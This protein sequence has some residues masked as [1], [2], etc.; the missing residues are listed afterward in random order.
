MWKHHLSHPRKGKGECFLYRF[1]ALGNFESLQRQQL[2]ARQQATAPVKLNVAEQFSISAAPN[3]GC[4]DNEYTD[5]MDRFI[6][7]QVF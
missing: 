3:D 1:L 4:L 7:S 5:I 2:A 6:L